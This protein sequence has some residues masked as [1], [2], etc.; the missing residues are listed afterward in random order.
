MHRLWVDLC[1]ERTT[2]ER[3]ESNGL[4]TGRQSAWNRASQDAKTAGQTAVV[5]RSQ[6]NVRKYDDL[7]QPAYPADYQPADYLG[8]GLPRCCP[9]PKSGS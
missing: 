7:H 6:H 1:G 2:I 9:N 3:V 5:P 8:S 4:S